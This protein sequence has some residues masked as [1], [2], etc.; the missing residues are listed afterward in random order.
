MRA[1]HRA[2][3]LLAPGR[4]LA[5][6][7][8]ARGAG[9]RR[10]GPRQAAPRRSR[11]CSQRREP[12][13]DRLWA[14]ELRRRA[15]RHA[16]GSARA[17]SARLAELAATHRRRRRPR[18]NIAPSSAAASTRLSPPA[19]ARL[20]AARASRAQAGQLDAARSPPVAARTRK[21]ISGAGI[22]RVAGQGGA[23]R[24][25]PPSGRDRAPHG[26]ARLACGWPT[27]RSA[28]CSRR[29]SMSR[30]RTRR[31][32]AARLVTILAQVRLRCSRRRIAASRHDCLIRSRRTSGDPKPRPR[33][34]G[35]GDRGAGGAARGGCGA[36]ARRRRRCRRDSTR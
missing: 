9:S 5:F 24:P 17:S 4:S 14:H 32:I 8:L 27:A 26:G 16:R 28:A 7:T 10:S 33:G 3:P 13:V 19:R 6:V 25:D 21:A 36:G 1:A 2:L 23:R 18:T 12:L 30:S 15:A 11:R 20:R 22:D 34:L 31:L 29:W 35:R